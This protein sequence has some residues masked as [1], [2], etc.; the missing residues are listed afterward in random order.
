M[1]LAMSLVEGGELIAAD[2]SFTRL[3]KLRENLSRIGFEEVPLVNIDIAAAGAPFRPLF[4]QVLI[5]APCS[6]TGTLRRHPEIRWRL[7]E[8]QLGSLARQQRRLLD[9]A[10]LLVPSGGR[11]VYAVCSM[12]P[13]EGRDV[14]AGFL[15]EHPE[16]RIE[17]PRPNLPP[18]AAVLVDEGGFLRTTPADGGL[19]GFFGAL[20]ARV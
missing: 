13:E 19:D 14:V 9:A 2:R 8:E 7:R 15:A 1:Q 20:L 18:P 4:D 12:E 5:D 17:D 6:G 16:W 11:V 10:C 3:G